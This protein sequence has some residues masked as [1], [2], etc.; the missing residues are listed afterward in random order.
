MTLRIRLRTCGTA[1]STW[2]STRLSG[3]AARSWSRA[4]PWW[5]GFE[6]SKAF[7]SE[8]T[9]DFEV[10]VTESLIQAVEMRID[11]DA[12]NVDS[13]VDTAYRSGLL[14]TPYFMDSLARFEQT[15]VGIREYFSRNGAR[16]RTPG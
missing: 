3:E 5:T 14:L 11:G 13:L 10:M 9:D 6:I 7:R 8:Y 12:D 4:T 15:P 2:R 1:I 16:D